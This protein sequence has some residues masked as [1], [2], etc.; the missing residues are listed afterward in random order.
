MSVS[1]RVG[2]LGTGLDPAGV[3]Q[4][5]ERFPVR[6]QAGVRDLVSREGS[7]ACVVIGGAIKTY[8]GRQTPRTGIWTRSCCRAAP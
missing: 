2:L 6:S 7:A 1:R 3:A 4:P 5:G 8:I